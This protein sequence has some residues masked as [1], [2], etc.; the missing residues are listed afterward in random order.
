MTYSQEF[1]YY[2]V[3]AYQVSL[4]IQPFFLDLV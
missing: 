2:L 1:F 3:D 4:S